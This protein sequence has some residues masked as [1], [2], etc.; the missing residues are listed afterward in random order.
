[1]ENFFISVKNPNQKGSFLMHVNGECDM[2]AV[3]IVTIITL[4]LD[5]DKEILDGVPEYISSC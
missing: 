4:L 5:L 2:R 1:M 3:Y